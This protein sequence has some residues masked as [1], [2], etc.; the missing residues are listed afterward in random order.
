M[1]TG[2]KYYRGSPIAKGQQGAIDRTTD[3]E[4]FGVTTNFWKLE[5]A[6]NNQGH[7]FGRVALGTECLASEIKAFPDKLIN[8]SGGS[9]LVDYMALPASLVSRSSY[10]RLA[11]RLDEQTSSIPTKLSSIA[12]TWRSISIRGIRGGLQ[13]VSVRLE[14]PELMDETRGF[15]EVKKLISNP[16]ISKAKP[17]ILIARVADIEVANSIA[18]IAERLLPQVVECCPLS[19]VALNR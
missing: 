3:L 19:V 15:N 16:E 17:E 7:T 13:A 12:V 2:K 10:L 6:H 18:E 8:T 14:S 1:S 4:G 9:L 5:I 11:D